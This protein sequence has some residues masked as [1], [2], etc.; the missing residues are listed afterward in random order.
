MAQKDRIH[1]LLGVYRGSSLT[2]FRVSALV[3]TFPSPLARIL[4]RSFRAFGLPLIRIVRGR[5]LRVTS[6]P[7]RYLGT[8]TPQET[9]RETPPG[10]ISFRRRLPH[11]GME[12]QLAPVFSI[13]L[14]GRRAARCHFNPEKQSVMELCR[15]RAVSRSVE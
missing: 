7:S 14:C 5:C 4:L 15:C 11:C 8:C 2:L 13:F 1:P 9:I 3:P 10:G 6:A 12:D